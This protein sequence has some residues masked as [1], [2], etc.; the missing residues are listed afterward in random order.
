MTEARRRKTALI[1]GASS[2]IGR[3]LADLCAR[4]G[5]DLVLVARRED[6]LRELEEK[7]TAQYAVN[8]RS[9]PMDLR[10]AAAPQ[11]LFDE[12]AG[13][14]IDILINN[15]G[16][17]TYG[18]FAET[19]VAS[20]V[21]IVRVNVLAVTHLTRLFLPSMVQRGEGR[22]L[23][24]ASMAAFVPGPLMAVYYST[25]AY[26]VSFSEALSEELR[27]SGVTV[28]AF[29]PGPTATE[30]QARARLERSGL[31]RIARAEVG[32]IAEAGYRAMMKGETVAVPG[33][34]NKV[35][36]VLIRIAP[37]FLIRRVVHELQLQ[38]E[39][40]GAPPT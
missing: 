9:V 19:D 32:P 39:R 17:A 26:V 10:D 16:F 38:V 5:Y 37:R 2:G 29:C 33:I 35:V 4:D 1:T 23:N 20:Q 13:T 8:V 36:T 34:L 7:W 28:T 25:K 30:F 6:R 21:E 24:L 18:P 40:P 14:P 11:R 15:A 27:G 22:I 12:L 31:L 3:A